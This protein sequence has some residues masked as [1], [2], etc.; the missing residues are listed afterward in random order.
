MLYPTFLFFL[1]LVFG[2]AHAVSLETRQFAQISPS[3]IPAEC[4]AYCDPAVSV[5]QECGLSTSTKP[6]CLCT[7]EN[8]AH[9]EQCADCFVAVKNSKPEEIDNIETA[10]N[11]LGRTCN[12]SGKPVP[13]VT[14]MSRVPDTQVLASSEPNAASA[15][16]PWTGIWWVGLVF[17]W[18]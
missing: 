13:A 15:T 6:S 11:G 3:T 5:M 7:A 17:L 1:T 16:L 8:F 18:L 12:S 9:F 2:L 10:I 4:K 14:V